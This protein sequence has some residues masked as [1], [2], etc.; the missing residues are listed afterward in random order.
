MMFPVQK[1][2]GVWYRR[3][4]SEP[5]QLRCMRLTLHQYHGRGL[6]RV[7]T[8]IVNTVRSFKSFSLCTAHAR[9]CIR[10]PWYPS[11]YA[12]F[13]ISEMFCLFPKL[14]KME[15]VCTKRLLEFW[16]WS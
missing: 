5:V 2:G 8:T 1:A 11:T 14:S 4:D 7:V 3:T 9:S 13:V 16:G 12:A 10:I 6:S 15:L